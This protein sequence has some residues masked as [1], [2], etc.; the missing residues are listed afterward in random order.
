MFRNFL[1]PCMPKGSRIF[2]F[3]YNAAGGQILMKAADHVLMKGAAQTI[4]EEGSGTG[5]T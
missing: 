1:I 5:D 2:L 4:D 3:E